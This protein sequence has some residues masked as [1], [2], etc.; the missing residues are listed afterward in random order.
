MTQMIHCG[1][2]ECV[3]NKNMRCSASS[4]RVRS[5]TDTGSPHSSEDTNCETFKPRS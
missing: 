1:V 4:I 5:R 2:E 3:H